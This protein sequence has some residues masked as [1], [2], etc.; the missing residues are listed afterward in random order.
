MCK[1]TKL[2]LRS[3]LESETIERGVQFLE[4]QQEMWKAL[5]ASSEI[6]RVSVPGNFDDFCINSYQCGTVVA[7]QWVM[8]MPSLQHVDL[9]SLSKLDC[10]G[11][12]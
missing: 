1:H 8:S 12:T 3:G 10:V 2:C 7:I 9:D 11:S 4:L 6:A 5:R